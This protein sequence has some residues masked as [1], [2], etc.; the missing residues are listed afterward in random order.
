[1]DSLFQDLLVKVKFKP[2][3]SDF[4]PP[5][6]KK[7]NSEVDHFTTSWSLLIKGA[8]KYNKLL[9]KAHGTLQKMGNAAKKVNV[10]GKADFGKAMAGIGVDEFLFQ[11]VGNAAQTARDNFFKSGSAF[12][13]T[14]GQTDNYLNSVNDIKETIGSAGFHGQIVAGGV[15]ALMA[16]PNYMLQKERAYEDKAISKSARMQ[17][18][19]DLAERQ[20]RL[21]RQNAFQLRLQRAQIQGGDY[22]GLLNREWQSTNM[23]ANLDPTNQREAN[24]KSEAL[25]KRGDLLKAH[26]RLL[27]ENVRHEQDSNNEKI[28][29]LQLEKQK[30]EALK[31]QQNLLQKEHKSAQANLGRLD[32]RDRSRLNK[33]LD[34]RGRGQELSSKELSFL[35]SYGGSMGADIAEK[36]FTRKG[37]AF[38]GILNK[39]KDQSGFNQRAQKV[40][41]DSEKIKQSAEQIDS[42]IQSL[43]ESNKKMTERLVEG[44]KS[45]QL[46][47]NQ[48]QE[49]LNKLREGSFQGG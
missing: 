49:E 2:D 46:Q 21:S 18:A 12:G 45:I 9:D 30:L 40:K 19:A 42:E 47:Y 24:R 38:G 33:I 17:Q 44:I 3:S 35:E 7:L 36:D 26:Q 31:Q 13:K 25:E 48:I 29:A 22:Q 6:L 10:G 16:Y 37:A 23:N 4:K 14:R 32:R 15:D 11:S 34:K 39:L 20:H 43:V 27:R 5:S 28:K 8:E 1:M 41:E